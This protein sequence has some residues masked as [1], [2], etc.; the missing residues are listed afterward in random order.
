MA[1]RVPVESVV[2][3]TWH[4]HHEGPGQQGE[5]ACDECRAQ[6]QAEADREGWSL[7]WAEAAA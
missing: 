4:V 1:L 3:A 6:I 2:P 5:P 7:A